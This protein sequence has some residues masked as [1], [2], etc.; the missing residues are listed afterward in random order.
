ERAQVAA[1]LIAR[2]LPGHRRRP[3]ERHRAVAI[4]GVIGRQ[5]DRR[6]GELARGRSH[7]ALRARLPVTRVAHRTRAA[8]VTARRVHTRDMRIAYG[9]TAGAFVDVL[10]T[11]LAVAA[12]ARGAGAAAV[13]ARRIHALRQR[14]AH[15]RLL[16]ALVDVR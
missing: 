13:A 5:R 3:T 7:H 15:A 10:A 2:V 16:L 11:G 14:V 6:Q 9:C 12:V 4:V 8:A 1:Q